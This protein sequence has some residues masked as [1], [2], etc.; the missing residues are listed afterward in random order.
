MMKKFA[1]LA[2]SAA[3]ASVSV[4]AAGQALEEVVVTAQKRV[5]SLQ[6]VPISGDCDLRRT[7]SGRVD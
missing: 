1:R 4:T 6:D 5:E 3:V 2:L 7:G